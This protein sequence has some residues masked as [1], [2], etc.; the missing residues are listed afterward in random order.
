MLPNV[1]TLKDP[2][3]RAA[4]A[5]SLYEAMLANTVTKPA[6]LA[7]TYRA[8][9]ATEHEELN[10]RLLTS[11]LLDIVWNFTKPADRPALAADIEQD[12]WQAM[13][14]APTS[15]L[16]KLLF[17]L[18]QNVA[19][20]TSAR[21]RL[22]AIWNEQR[23]PAGVTLT[24]DDYTA[25]ALALAVRDYPVADILSRQLAR[26]KNP[27]RQKRLTFMMPAL[28]AN[29]A[30]R[31]QFFA[32]LSTESNRDHEA[33]VTSALGYLHHPL[34][35]ETSAK[36]LPKSLALLEEIQRTG[37]IFF[38]EQWLRSTFSAYQTPDVTALVRRFLS[39][40]PN[41]NPRLRAKL[42]QAADGPFRAGKILYG[43]GR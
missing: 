38:P 16:K 18:Y 15:G 13:E 32:S 12:A 31:D 43:T 5:I 7:T 28:S 29:V 23:A 24:E 42:L 33:W 34:R 10:L 9:L 25:L 20:S 37:D 30:E 36:Y 2:V 19:L 3:M 26:I 41:Y 21:Q 6:Q 35:A 11:Q 17:R 39:D 4:A 27:D 8:M 40:R 14:N 22:Y 1:A